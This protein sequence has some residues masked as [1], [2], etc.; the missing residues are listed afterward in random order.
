MLIKAPKGVDNQEKIAELEAKLRR[1]PMFNSTPEQQADIAKYYN[2]IKDLKEQEKASPKPFQGVPSHFGGEPAI[3]ASMRLKDR[4]GPNGEKLLHLEELQSDWHQ[5]GRERGYGELKK[6][7]VEAYYEDEHGNTIPIGYGRTKEE[8]DSATDP[9]WKHLVDIKYR[10]FDQVVGHGVADAPFKKNWEEMALK[11]LIHHAAE[12]GYHGIVVTPGAEQADRYDLS[13][14]VNSISWS[15][16]SKDRGV[17]TIDAPGNKIVTAYDPKTGEFPR[18]ESGHFAGK[19]LT[20]VVGKEMAQK[21]LSETSGNLS[22]EGLKIGGEGMKGFYDKKVPNILNS[23]GKKYGVKTQ[24]HGHAIENKEKENDFYAML[25]ANNVRGVDW[26]RYPLEKQREM[27]NDW[28]DKTSA[29]VHHFPITEE[30]RSDILKNGLPLYHEGGIIH[31]AQ[32][33]NVQP[34]TAQMKLAL[35]KANPLNIQ[36]IGADEAPDMMPKAYLPPDP[37]SGK[38]VPPGGVSTPSGMPIGGIDMSRQPGQQLLPM[39]LLQPQQ[40]LPPQPDQSQP[41]P[42]PQGGSNILQMTPQGQALSAMKPTQPQPQAMADGGQPITIQRKQDIGGYDPAHPTSASLAKA[43]KEAIAH[44]L[45][46]PEHERIINSHLAEERVG[47]I[48]GRARTGPMRGRSKDLLG[49]NAKLLKS[50]KGKGAEPIKLDDGRGVETTG[51]AL[52]PA[53]EIGK[54]NTCPNHASCKEECLGKTSGN[55]FKLGGGPDLEAFKGPRLNSLNKTMAM[56]HDP[57]AFA[58]KL[59]DEIEAAKALAAKGNNHLGLRLNVLSDINPEVHRPIIEGHPDVTFYDY[60]KMKYKPIARNHHYTY[61]STGLE[62]DGAPNPHTNW[63]QM[64][65]RLDSGDNV[66]MA[67]THKR[68]LPKKVL[69]ESTG[70]QYEVIDGDTHDFRPL[71]KVAPDE[72]GVIIGLKNKKASGKM[73]NAHVD[74]HGFFVYYD[75]KE[76][77]AP[78]A[79]GKMIFAKDKKGLTIPTNTT[80]R[81][82]PQKFEAQGEE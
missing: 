9:Y 2:Q 34:T 21:I 54:F 62:Q 20:E 10:N 5:Q 39:N 43:F 52:A 70:N 31:K 75:P 65:D 40:P 38:F 42:A 15:P 35:M 19:N 76:K 1:I 48:I 18:F 59:Y 80:V 33:G 7:V 17:L 66:A 29:K 36:S 67:F 47:D 58:V 41:A 45:S 32:G 74:S 27:L 6:P 81:I 12:K 73:Q 77:M 14:Q 55:Y 11:R 22:G 63:H 4:T 57:H 49:K 60:T 78:N 82:R 61:S 44:H 26:D 46:L 23:I 72:K 25:K 16:S 68:H 24:L 8:A 79:K 30:M 64:R 50:E 71:D 13:K 56:I 3:L 69:D 28:K 37:Q 51:L 53:L